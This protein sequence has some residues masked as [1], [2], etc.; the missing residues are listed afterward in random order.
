MK[1]T[2]SVM[3]NVYEMLRG[4][5]P[6]KKW[7]LPHESNITFSFLDTN[8]FYGDYIEIDGRPRIRIAS[9]VKSLD[10]LIE[11]ISHEMCHMKLDLAGRDDGMEHGPAFKRL[12]KEV[13]NHLGFDL[14]EF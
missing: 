14:K 13:C 10:K 11:T 12:A 7:R 6:F 1:I 5:E 9:L 8:Q 4:V 3:A 2:R